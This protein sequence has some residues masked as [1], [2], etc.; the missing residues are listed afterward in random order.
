MVCVQCQTQVIMVL[1]VSQYCI[2]HYIRNIILCI[3]MIII[4]Y[5]SDVC[6]TIIH[7]NPYLS[8]HSPTCAKCIVLHPC[9]IYLYSIITTMP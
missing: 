6:P 5:D 1:D 2:S 3:Y 8:I 9:L 7:D 4:H